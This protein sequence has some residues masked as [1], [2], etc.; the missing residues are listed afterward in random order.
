GI[1][2]AGRYPGGG[3]SLKSCSPDHVG[4]RIRCK[5]AREV[6]DPVLA[7]DLWRAGRLRSRPVASVGRPYQ[8]RKRPRIRSNSDDGDGDHGPIETR[9]LKSCDVGKQVQE[10]LPNSQDRKVS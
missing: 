5:S 6:R 9:K 10:T 4:P 3:E 1:A 7:L 2:A 8:R